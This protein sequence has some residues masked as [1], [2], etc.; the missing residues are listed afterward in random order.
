MNDEARWTADAPGGKPPP[1]QLVITTVDSAAA[2][3]ALAC[4]LVESRLAACVQIVPVQSVYRWDGEVKQE[5]E[6]LL[7]I[8]TATGFAEV[9]AAILE[10]SPYE[11]PEILQLPIGEGSADYLQWLRSAARS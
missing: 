3:D 1:V 11:L 10:Q 5:A 9:E 8:K 6:W 7:L 2:A 4:A